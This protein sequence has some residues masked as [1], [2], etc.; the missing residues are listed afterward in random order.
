ME[1]RSKWLAVKQLDDQLDAFKPV[2]RQQ[3]PK[4]GWVRAIRDALGMSAEQ[5][6]KRAGMAKQ[7]V[8]TAESRELHSKITLANL[9]KLA[10]AMDCDV[11]YALVPRSSLEDLVTRQAKAIAR[12]RLGL[13]SH[14]MALED[15]RVAEELSES[16][17]ERLVQELLVE[18]PRY[19]WD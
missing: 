11:V 17:F 8:S 3:R 2:Q 9:K 15:Q 6:G 14:T 5:L 10:D 7:A 18:R 1:A 19:L 13:V 4:R 16:Q 12:E